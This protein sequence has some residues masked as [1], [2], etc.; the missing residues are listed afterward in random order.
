MLYVCSYIVHETSY[1]ENECNLIAILYE[2]SLLK[3]F[4]VYYIVCIV[5]MNFS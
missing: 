2:T 1:K 4:I 5:R 3:S